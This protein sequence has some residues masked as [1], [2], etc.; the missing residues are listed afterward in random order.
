MSDQALYDAV[1]NFNHAP[2]INLVDEIASTMARDEVMYVAGDAHEGY[3][4][5]H[6]IC[7]L[8]INAAVDLLNRGHGRSIRNFDFTLVWEPRECAD[9]QNDIC[10]RLD[11]AAAQRKLAAARNYPELQAE[12][13][14]ALA[15]SGSVG[16]QHHPDLA[17][18]AG[19]KAATP[20]AINFDIECL[21]HLDGNTAACFSRES[22]TPFYEL[23]GERQ[24]AAGHYQRVLRYREHM[25]PLADALNSH[26]E[27]NC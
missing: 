6:D 27:K 2:F 5:A 12:V 21:R 15:G 10:V 17:D 4:P 20:S 1:L 25:L 7:R 3:N 18:R 8:V 24:V 19:V 26:V 23:Y 16:L 13:A 9:E 14:A 11:A 22:E